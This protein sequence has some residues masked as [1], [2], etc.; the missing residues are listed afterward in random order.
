[1]L[2]EQK[3]IITTLS[4]LLFYFIFINNSFASNL[5]KDPDVQIFIN[6][7][8]KQHNFNKNELESLFSQVKIKQKILDAISRPAE[9]SK[10]WH[11]YRKIFLTPKRINQGVKFWQ[12]NSDIIE[13]AEKTYG[14]APEI[15]VSIIGV[16]TFYGR[17]QGSYRVM[18]AL[19]TLAFKY[20]KRSKFFRGEL[21]HFLI[22]SKE[23]KFDPLSRKGSY[24]GAMGMGQ[25]IPSSFQSYAID[26]DGDGEKD[27]WSNNADAIGSVAHYFKRHGWKKGQ[28]VTDQL[29]LNKKNTIKSKDGCRRSC[30]L[31]LI[32]ADFKQKGLQGETSVDDKTP[33]ILLILKQKSG[34]EYWLGYNNF[35]VISRYNHSTLYS[36]AVYQLSQEIKQAYEAEKRLKK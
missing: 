16:E 20:P 26:F 19:S 32:V 14:V 9:K 10:A 18:D 24:A 11:E 29:Q 6:E 22:M 28:P 17:L 3:V 21:K 31:K 30:K 1:M 5:D 25:F 7:M 8:V 34:K 13:Y 35:Y 27:I 2:S 12:D 36:M 4:M 33:A 15:M 23:Q